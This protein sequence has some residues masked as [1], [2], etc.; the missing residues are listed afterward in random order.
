LRRISL[1]EQA[2]ELGRIYRGRGRL[3]I[4][5]VPLRDRDRA[6]A[7]RRRQDVLLA[8]WQSLAWFAAHPAVLRGYLEFCTPMIKHGS[9]DDGGDW[10]PP[11]D[12]VP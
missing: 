7:H 3:F 1:A 5:P 4:G 6:R 10:R 2:A 12:F 8:A 9:E 11:P